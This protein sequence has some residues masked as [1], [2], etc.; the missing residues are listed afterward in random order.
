MNR[1]GSEYT[2][3]VRVL[4]GFK[5]RYNLMVN[6]EITIDLTQDHS[7]SKTGTLT[8]FKVV[9]RPQEDTQMDE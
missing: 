2:Y 1:N 7:Q 6:G 9:N 4:G 8:N 5:Y 3:S